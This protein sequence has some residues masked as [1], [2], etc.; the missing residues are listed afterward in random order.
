MKRILALLLSAMI[1]VSF[2]ACGK[3][4]DAKTQTGSSSSAT[5]DTQSEESESKEGA[6]SD[7]SSSE[8][9]SANASSYSEIGKLNYLGGKK[10]IKGLKLTGN[11]AGTDEGINGRDSGTENIRA[12][13][14]LNEWVNFQIDREDEP[15]TFA[16]F[17]IKHK[18]DTT[19]YEK[20]SYDELNGESV[21]GEDLIKSDD[22]TWGSGYVNPDNGDPGDYD[23]VF[24]EDGA[25][26]AFVTVHMFAEGELQGKTDAELESLTEG[27]AE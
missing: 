17:F 19:A 27:L 25:A 20:M 26:T 22:N 13:F 23:I 4:D 1:L 5:T 8:S 18:E 3:N 14:E 11:V 10:T 15:E 21:A 2:A 24:V 16:V 6:S 12:I 7:S 9:T